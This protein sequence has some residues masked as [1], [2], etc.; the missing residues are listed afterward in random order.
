MTELRAPLYDYNNGQLKP[1]DIYPSDEYD[2]QTQKIHGASPLKSFFNL[3]ISAIGGGVLAFPYAYS[4]TGLASGIIVTLMIL[5]IVLYSEYVITACAETL[6]SS[7]YVETVTRMFNPTV[8][9]FC[10]FIVW[11]SLMGAAMAY[12]SLIG[13]MGNEL[14]GYDERLIMLCAGCLIVF[15]CFLKKTAHVGWI[16]GLGL[17]PI[18]VLLFVIWVRS[19]QNV[20]DGSVSGVDQFKW[21]SNYLSAFPLF[22]F[23]YQCHPQLPPI[24][25]ELQDKTVAKMTNII[26]GAMFVESFVYISIGA[27]G[28]VSFGSN[29][30]SN[31]ID[32]YSD[33]DIPMIV[34][35]CTMIAHFLFAIPINFVTSR[36]YFYQFVGITKEDRDIPWVHTSTTLGLF[37]TVV[38][39]AILAPGASVFFS[40]TGSTTGVVIVFVFPGL[41]AYY[42]PDLLWRVPFVAACFVLTFVVGIGGTFMTVKD[43]FY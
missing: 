3:T 15:P 33:D 5:P 7:N 21:D 12:I 39:L 19:F 6:G 8:G 10:D 14:T 41:F 37:G 40:L 34:V 35:R 24:Y 20:V 38:L 18:V 17:A 29:T 31:I 1:S 27:L 42:R 11:V 43:I 28:Y 36:I 32:N 30:D 16:S 4:Q 26:Y 2:I 25:H 23:A 9:R 22:V 13:D